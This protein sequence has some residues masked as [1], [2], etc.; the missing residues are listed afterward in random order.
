MHTVHLH[1]SALALITLRP[2]PFFS[3]VTQEGVYRTVG[4]NI[5]V[6][7]LINAFFGKEIRP[8]CTF[9]H[10]LCFSSWAR[11][12]FCTAERFCY[13]CVKGG[14]RQ[15]RLKLDRGCKCSQKCHS[16]LRSFHTSHIISHE[17]VSLWRKNLQKLHSASTA[18][19]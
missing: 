8:C 11:L 9:V 2:P 13:F 19:S 1:C 6:Q 5:Q 7:K 12:P 17:M 3:G 16:G 14:T 15:F 18:V 10:P 4:S